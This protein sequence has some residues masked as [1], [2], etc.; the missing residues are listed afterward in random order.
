M[1]HDP[2]VTLDNKENWKSEVDKATIN[3]LKKR[4]STI[5][6]YNFSTFSY[7]KKT[8][9][10]AYMKSKGNVKGKQKGSKCRGIVNRQRKQKK[11]KKTLR[12]IFHIANHLA[13][14]LKVIDNKR[15]QFHLYLDLL[16]C[17]LDKSISNFPLTNENLLTIV[18]I[19]YMNQLRFPLVI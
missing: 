16:I 4:S 8:Y 11:K 10:R 5:R 13:N 2:F 19:I 12:S 1:Q 14:R 18:I 9:Q 7:N 15:P 6:S 3:T 17:I